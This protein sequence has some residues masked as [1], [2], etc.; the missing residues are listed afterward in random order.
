MKSLFCFCLSVLFGLATPLQ[1]QKKQLPPDVLEAPSLLCIYGQPELYQK[2]E[3]PVLEDLTR[4]GFQIEHHFHVEENPTLAQQNL[5]EIK[6]TIAGESLSY[7]I[8]LTVFL[9]PGTKPDL[10]ADPYEAQYEWVMLVS[11]INQEQFLPD[12]LNYT[13]IKGGSLAKLFKKLEKMLAKR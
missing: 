9:K 13:V 1:A 2:L 5:V 4:L 11:E 7:W 3:E 12:N 10:L 6:E 8:T